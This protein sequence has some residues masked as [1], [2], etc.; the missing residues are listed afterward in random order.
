MTEWQA[1]TIEQRNL[2]NPAFCAVVLWNVAKWGFGISLT[3]LVGEGNIYGVLGLLEGQRM[4]IEPEGF[5]DTHARGGAE[6]R[7]RAGDIAQKWQP[8]GVGSIEVHKPRE[9]LASGNNETE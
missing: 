3:E 5:D 8:L 4:T 7:L 2:L 1:R 6:H 9:R